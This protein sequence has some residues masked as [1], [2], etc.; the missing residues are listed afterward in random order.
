MA[1]IAIMCVPLLV[2]ADVSNGFLACVKSARLGIRSSCCIQA[3][4]CI[5]VLLQA[6]QSLMATCL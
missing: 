2:G 4:W 5:A 3:D 1:R 6:A